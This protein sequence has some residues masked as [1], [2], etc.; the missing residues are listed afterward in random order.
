MSASLLEFADIAA[1]GVSGKIMMLTWLFS[2]GLAEVPN[3]CTEEIQGLIVK[4]KLWGCNSNQGQISCTKFVAN[5][6]FKIFLKKKTII[7]LHYLIEFN[8][9][10]SWKQELLLNALETVL[11]AMFWCSFMGALNSEYSFISL[12]LWEVGTMTSLYRFVNCNNLFMVYS[13]C[14]FSFQ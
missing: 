2:G 5:P 7:V 14:K 3:Y 10:R 4:R 12:D 1:F 11:L 13:S 9:C 8:W 6:F